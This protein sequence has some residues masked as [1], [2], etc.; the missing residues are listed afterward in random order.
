MGN[1]YDTTNCLWT[2]DSTGDLNTTPV[3]V[4]HILYFPSLVSDDFILTD[5][6]DSVWLPLKAGTLA[7]DPIHISFEPYGRRAATLKVGT[8][9]GGTAYVLLQ[10]SRDIHV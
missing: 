10:D 2:I 1:T 8:I 4:M 3:I 6:D 7:A 5:T 9:D